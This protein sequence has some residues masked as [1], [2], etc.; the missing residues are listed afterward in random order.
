MGRKEDNKA[1]RKARREEVERKRLD[2]INAKFVL[3][4]TSRRTFFGKARKGDLAELNFTFS[5]VPVPVI[6]EEEPDEGLVERTAQQQAL[7]E[8]NEKKENG[9]SN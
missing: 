7:W 8:L 9:E 2:A 4:R 3:G 6:S 1:R 5:G